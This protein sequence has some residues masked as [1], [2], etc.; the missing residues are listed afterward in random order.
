MIEHPGI[1]NL[2][3]L[4]A[5]GLQH[6]QPQPPVVLARRQQI[7]LVRP[8]PLPGRV[9]LMPDPLPQA[10]DDLVRGGLIG[11]LLQRPQPGVGHLLHQTRLLQGVLGPARAAQVQPAHQPGQ[12]GALQQQGATDDDQGGQHQHRA[13]RDVAGQQEHG[14]Q[15]DHAAHAGPRDDRRVLP[16]R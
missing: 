3:Q 6:Q 13:V 11:L 14:G 12:R 5:L 1:A 4:L 8:Q 16:G 15:R 9:H 2:Q 10:V 7:R